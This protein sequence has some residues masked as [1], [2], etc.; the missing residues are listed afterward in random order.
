MVYL[1][2]ALALDLSLLMF[3]F[4]KIAF[5]GKKPYHNAAAVI[6]AFIS[7]PAGYYIVAFLLEF[8]KLLTNFGSSP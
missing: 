6:A 2:G 4:V 1:Y 3:W 5:N 8:F 7:A